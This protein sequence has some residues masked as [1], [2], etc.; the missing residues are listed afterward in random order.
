MLQETRTGL[1][2]KK[3]SGTWMSWQV[4]G[5]HVAMLESAKSAQIVLENCMEERKMNLLPFSPQHW[6]RAVPTVN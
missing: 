4:M 3:L 5:R 2:S 6:L 1:Y